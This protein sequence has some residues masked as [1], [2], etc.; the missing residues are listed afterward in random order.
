M[1]FD[2]RLIA[3]LCFFS[4]SACSG[5]LAQKETSISNNAITANT[6]N[7][8]QSNNLTAKD[9]I[10]AVDKETEKSKS[11]LDN[12]PK[13]IR[14]FFLLLPEKYFLLEGCQPASDKECRQAKLDY[15]KNFAEIEDTA[16]GY[17]KGGCDGAQSCLEMAI[18]KRS[19]GKYVTGL[20]VSQE[21]MERYHFLVYEN[22]K[23]TDVSTQIVPQFSRK[24]MYEMPR[25]GTTVK[26]FAKKILEQGADYEVSEKG[27]KLY[28]LEWNGEK[29]LIRK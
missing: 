28:D 21:M 10:K 25:K 3:L 29:F 12:Q 4:V 11:T 8:E 19:D 1:K 26:V 2:F 18:F 9:G 27:A 23:W 20:A 22:E 13:T 15:L 6:Q 14:D 17:L 24:N 7:Q 5:S 16:N